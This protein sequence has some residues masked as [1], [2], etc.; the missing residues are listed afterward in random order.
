MLQEG[1]RKGKPVKEKGGR[2]TGRRENRGSNKEEPT[3]G[4]RGS[5]ATGGEGEPA[6][7]KATGERK[8]PEAKKGKQNH[9]DERVGGKETRANEER[10]KKRRAGGR[11]VP[12]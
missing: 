12:G 3:R 10:Q 8:R 4:W 6:A 5:E 11:S 9:Q 1:E 2:N 7:H